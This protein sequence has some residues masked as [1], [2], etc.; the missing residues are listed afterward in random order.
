MARLGNFP[1]GKEKREIHEWGISLG[2]KS[3]EREKIFVEN[4][5]IKGRQDQENGCRNRVHRIHR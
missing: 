3:V 5:S 2:I 4:A 1:T